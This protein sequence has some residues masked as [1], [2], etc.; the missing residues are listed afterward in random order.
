MNK[1]DNQLTSNNLVYQEEVLNKFNDRIKEIELFFSL[2]DKFESVNPHQLISVEDFIGTIIEEDLTINLD[3]ETTIRNIL[4]KLRIETADVDLVNI[5]KS[6]SILILYNLIESTI[7]NVDRFVLKTISTE[8][9]FFIEAT[10]KIKK[11]WIEHIS[12]FN[13]DEY[14]KIAVSILDK[15]QRI[16]INIEKQINDDE[17]EFQGNLDPRMIDA[18]LDKYGIET[19]KNQMLTKQTQ[20][21]SIRN[22]AIWRN[23]LAHGKYSFATFGRDKLRYKTTG[24]RGKEN[25]IY[26]LKESA[27]EFLEICLN[28]IEQYIDNKLYKI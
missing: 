26:F 13:K 4:L 7:S 27:Y 5:F 25:D 17:K 14:L 23:D 20:R 18:L 19:T 12:N 2:I 10:E 21:D 15:V 9:I 28:N 1:I 16:K 11:L 24:N 22:I 8:N 6:N 3:L